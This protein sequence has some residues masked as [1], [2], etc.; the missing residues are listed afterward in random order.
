[1]STADRSG[2]P[3][4]LLDDDGIAELQRIGSAIGERDR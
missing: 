4:A 3:V 2:S 1:M